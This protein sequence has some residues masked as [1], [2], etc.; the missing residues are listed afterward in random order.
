LT[1]ETKSLLA[2][3]AYRQALNLAWYRVGRLYKRESRIL[4]DLAK[5]GRSTGL[6]AMSL[7]NGKGRFSERYVFLIMDSLVTLKG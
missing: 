3:P 2:S 1:L 4:R 7:S 6:T 5:R